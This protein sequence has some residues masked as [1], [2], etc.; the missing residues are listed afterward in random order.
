MSAVATGQTVRTPDKAYAVVTGGGLTASGQVVTVR[1]L[2]GYEHLTASGGGTY[3]ADEVTPVHVCACATL[4][5]RPIWG[6]QQGEL[7]ST[8]CDLTRR[9]GRRSKFLPGHDAKAKGFLIK[10][11]GYAQTLENGKDALE[12]ARDLGDKI[13]MAVAKGIDNAR[14]DRPAKATPR[15]DES[16]ACRLQRELKMTPV[17]VRNLARALTLED[18]RVESN[19]PTGQLLAL[20]S[21]GL[22]SYDR[23]TDLGRRA[24]DFEPL[25][26]DKVVCS[27]A[28]GD[29]TAHNY[30]RAFG[31][32]ECRRC[33]H[34]DVADI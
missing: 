15:A 5:Y 29:Y 6:D 32:R 30:N 27:D 20:R 16:E 14:E 8:G 22:V 17:M 34:E 25:E 3:A 24:L 18:G 7:I 2:P 26:A 4:A 23:V 33:G 19:V 1:Y 13:V 9:P 11:A 12:T 21:R 28:E 10:A 31:E